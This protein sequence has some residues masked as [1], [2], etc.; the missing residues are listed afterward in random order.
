MN[1]VGLEPY[2]TWHLRLLFK[3][4]RGDCRKTL[5]V[6]SKYLPLYLLCPTNGKKISGFH[7]T[8]VGQPANRALHQEAF[9][10]VSRYDSGVV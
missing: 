5:A 9:L 1:S 2:A 3:M 6:R 7:T 4:R 8:I 10:L